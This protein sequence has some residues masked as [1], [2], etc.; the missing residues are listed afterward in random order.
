MSR[1]QSNN[2]YEKDY[3][4]RS[5]DYRKPHERGATFVPSYGSEMAR[6]KTKMCN[7]LLRN[8]NC[9]LGQNCTYAHNKLEQRKNFK[10][11]I[12]I[13]VKDVY[14]RIWRKKYQK[15]CNFGSKSDLVPEMPRFQEERRFISG[16]DEEDKKSSE[17]ERNPSQATDFQNQEPLNYAHSVQTPIVCETPVP[18]DSDITDAYRKLKI[19]NLDL[20]ATIAKLHRDK[21]ELE[22]K[23][24]E[25]SKMSMESESPET[26]T[27][28]DFN[29]MV[30]ELQEENSQ[31][32]NRIKELLSKGESKSQS[33][34]VYYKIILHAINQLE[35]V[36]R[37][38]LTKKLMNYPVLTPSLTIVDKQ[39]VFN[40]LDHKPEHPYNSFKEL[41]KA[42]TFPPMKSVVDLRYELKRMVEEQE[43]NDGDV[44]VSGSNT[45]SGDSEQLLEKISQLE[46][47]LKDRNREIKGCN[48]HKTE[49]KNKLYN[50]ELKVAELEDELA[51]IKKGNLKFTRK[52]LKSYTEADVADY[53]R[54]ITQ[55]HESIRKYKKENT[56]YKYQISVLKW[57]LSK[58]GTTDDSA[59]QNKQ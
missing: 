31:L 39:D 50:C 22:Q 25:S 42:K 58:L 34:D 57:D 11:P 54:Q 45:L 15:N 10:E 16:E 44:K 5:T 3:Q 49:L 27:I 9:T 37:S 55:L 36:T 12:P 23:L 32:K 4:Y 56:Y 7:Y 29:R 6:Y 52:S 59:T 17:I 40:I 46:S 35:E 33:S 2:F 43:S 8:G 30:K 51:L 41:Q 47:R 38:Y 53:K 1:Y 18:Q 14:K 19:E 28:Q 26:D 21:E 13:W 48:V 24:Q 20:Q